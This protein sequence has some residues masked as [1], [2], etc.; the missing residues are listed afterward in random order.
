[1]RIAAYLA[2]C[3]ADQPLSILGC[4]LARADEKFREG[5]RKSTTVQQDKI[6]NATKIRVRK[7]N[8]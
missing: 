3:I 5:V 2:E 8:L 1:V 4:V 6:E 7:T